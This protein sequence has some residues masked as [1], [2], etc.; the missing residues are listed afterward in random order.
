MKNDQGKLEDKNRR[1]QEAMKGQRTWKNTSG[2]N[3]RKEG[4][5]HRLATRNEL[6]DT[7]LSFSRMQELLRSRTLEL[8][9]AQPFLTNAV[10]L[11]ETLHSE[12]LRI[13]CIV[14]DSFELQ[15]SQG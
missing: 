11:L 3:R 15:G 10:S 7:R 5:I 13:T 6:M 8:R 4:E 12:I 9:G 14:A 1:L 2:Q